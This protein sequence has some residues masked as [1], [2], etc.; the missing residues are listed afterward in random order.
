M[1]DI[2]SK[3]YRAN[4][5][6][7]IARTRARRAARGRDPYGAEQ[8]RRRKRRQQIAEYKLKAGCIDCGYNTHQAALDFDHI[9]GEKKFTIG[10]SYTRSWDSIL[11]EINKCEV[12]CA[13]CHRVVTYE[14]KHG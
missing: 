1:P 3:W 10:G 4:K 12:R 11:K 5:E 13:N 14:R 2:D 7:V 9:Q 6:K 8:I